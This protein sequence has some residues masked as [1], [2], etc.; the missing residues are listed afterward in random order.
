MLVDVILKSE[1]R[2]TQN[3]LPTSKENGENIKRSLVK[4]ISWR[5]VGTLDTILISFLITGAIRMAFSIGAI[6]LITK[7]IL[8]F[9]H[10]RAWDKIKWGKKC[11]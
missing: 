5:V 10:E 4:T 11:Q 6:E 1:S 9:F 7:L 3:V 2:K 8:Y